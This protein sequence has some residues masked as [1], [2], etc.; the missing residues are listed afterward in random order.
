MASSL[1]IVD[2]WAQPIDGGMAK[3]GT[4]FDLLA[5]RSGGK[6]F[7]EAVKNREVK[8]SIEDHA[9]MMDASGVSRVLLTAW[10][11]PEGVMVSN[12][13]VAE[14]TR[15]FPGK[16]FGVASVDL[17][18][19]VQACRTLEKMVKQHGFKALRVIQWLWGLPPTDKHYFPLYVKCV[20]LDI[21]ICFQVG[22][23]GPMRTSETGR[24]IPYI[25]EVALK[26]PDLKIVCGHIGYPWTDEMIAVAW[27][28]P[29]VYIDTS[30]YLPR[31]YPK[32]LVHFMKTYG[33][34][35]VLFGTNFPMLTWDR[36]V[37]DVEKLG[38]SDE[39][40]TLFMFKNAERVFKLPPLR[41]SRL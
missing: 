23:T 41:R 9:A 32:Q 13:R 26:F 17:L 7:A 6:A 24:P 30:A 22:H 11:A 18:K 14:F 33:K 10:T 1:P 5:K 31:Y 25:D 12:E 19:P 3:L 40:L 2:A 8:V 29:N 37:K 34:K 16:F 28:H 36:C 4:A 15:K 39:V 35:K 38:L 20:E 21:P 27:K